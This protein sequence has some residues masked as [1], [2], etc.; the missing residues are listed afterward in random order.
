V[1]WAGILASGFAVAILIVLVCS[2]LAERLLPESRLR[3]LNLLCLCALPLGLIALG[4]FATLEHSKQVSFCQSCHTPMD[5]YVSDMV[6]PRSETLAAAHYKNRFIQ[7]EQCYTCHVDHGISGMVK[8]KVGGARDFYHWLAASPTALGEEQIQLHDAAG[9]RNQRCLG[10]HA[11]S[12]KLLASG[13]G[14]HLDLADELM[15]IDPKTGASEMSCME[16][17]GP[18]HPSLEAWKAKIESDGRLQSWQDQTT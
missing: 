15:T 14:I 16:C 8:A 13:D 18:A 12:Q 1:D 4:G 2:I 6:D 11:G 5:M 7:S 10:C 3:F 9:Y 17:H